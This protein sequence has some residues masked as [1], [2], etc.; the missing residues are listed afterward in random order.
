M[1]AFDRSPRKLSQRLFLDGRFRRRPRGAPPLAVPDL[2][3]PVL[4]A[5]AR[6]ALGWADGDDPGGGSNTR[7]VGGSVGTEAAEPADLDEDEAGAHATPTTA[8][9]AGRRVL[10]AAFSKVGGGPR[11]PKH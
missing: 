6:R 8:D 1:A 10:Y 9:L 3:P 11:T 4:G 2:R 5:S 7:W